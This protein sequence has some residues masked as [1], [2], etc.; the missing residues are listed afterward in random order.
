M[1][2]I[3]LVGLA[4]E[5]PHLV[6]TRDLCRQNSPDGRDRAY[7]TVDVDVD[8]VDREDDCWEQRRSIEIV[9]AVVS[10]PWWKRYRHSVDKGTNKSLCSY[11]GKSQ[12]CWSP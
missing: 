12:Y 9:E 5:W 3:A 11:L 7:T 2:T 6:A 10:T 1:L 8:V 4:N